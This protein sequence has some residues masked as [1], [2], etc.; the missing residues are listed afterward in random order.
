MEDKKP[1][2]HSG[3]RKPFPEEKPVMDVVRHAKDSVAQRHGGRVVR[4]AALFKSFAQT[5]AAATVTPRAI[6]IVNAAVGNA[7]AGGFTAR[8]V[9]DATG[10]NEA[11]PRRSGISQA[12]GEVA[13]SLRRL[14][15]L[16]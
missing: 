3:S 12:Q 14:G 4:G 2:F 11:A 16:R 6:D 9:S 10:G 1:T 8:I 5:S 13:A 7:V 15:V